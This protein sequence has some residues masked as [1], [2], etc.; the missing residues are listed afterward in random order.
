MPIPPLTDVSSKY[1]APMGRLDWHA[2]DSE[3]TL[4]FHLVRLDFV[5]G[6]YDRGG[7]Y[8][9]RSHAHGYVYRA[10]STEDVFLASRHEPILGHV[11]MFVRGKTRTEAKNVVKETYPNAT[12]FR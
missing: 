10:V 6:D 2:V 4:K 11:E 5:D 12:F 7:A 9:G 1:G 8:W 3:T